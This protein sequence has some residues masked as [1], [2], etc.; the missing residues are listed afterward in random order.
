MLFSYRSINLCLAGCIMSFLSP[1]EKTLVAFRSFTYWI[2]YY[3]SSILKNVSV[4]S[5]SLVARKVLFE[6]YFAEQLVRVCQPFCKAWYPSYAMLIGGCNINC[7]SGHTCVAVEDR[8]RI[9]YSTTLLMCGYS[10]LHKMS[11]LHVNGLN[12]DIEGK[13]RR[14]LFFCK[15]CVAQA[16]CLRRKDLIKS[17]HVTNSSQTASSQRDLERKRVVTVDM[18]KI[19]KNVIK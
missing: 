8:R 2:R 13:L 12:I 17:S 18:L 11:S 10:N 6:S 5:M 1:V 14:S 19:K 3:N 7:F 15:S 16:T 9:T 4:K